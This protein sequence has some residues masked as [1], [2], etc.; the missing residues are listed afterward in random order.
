MNLGEL[1][2]ELALF[3]QDSSHET[4]F[5]SWINEAVLEIANDF[6][7]P[8]LKLK[9]PTTLDVTEDDWLYDMP[10]AYMKNLFKCYDSDYN[11]IA[12]KRELGD[13][14]SIDIDHDET[15]DNVTT[16]AVRDRQIG[17]YPMAAE[18]IKL[19]F[20]EYPTDLVDPGN[21]LTCIPK[22]YHSRVVL[23][24]VIIK[25]YHLLQDMTENPPHK[26]LQWW[27]ANYRAG[28]YGERGGDIGML[29]CFARDKKPKRT[30]GR[31]P[32]P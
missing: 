31:N 6:S 5:T 24:K 25:N 23:S 7:L 1:E 30:G 2:A 18:S 4:Y 27:K 11:K 9:E 15:G 10:D 21:E 14:D 29:N 19:W 16:V 8:A 17:I 32:L 22:Q 20:Y 26:S 13:I 28:L 12:I 3:V